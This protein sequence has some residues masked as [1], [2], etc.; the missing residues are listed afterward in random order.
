MQGPGAYFHLVLMMEAV[1]AIAQESARP[2]LMTSLWSLVFGELKVEPLCAVK[3]G[4]RIIR[5]T[6][7]A[8][9]FLL[10]QR[11]PPLNCSL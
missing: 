2:A 4:I 9:S 10:S 8:I 5:L 1:K 7:L 6:P 3:C 11:Y